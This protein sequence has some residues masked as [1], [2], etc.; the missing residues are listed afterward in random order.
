MEEGDGFGDVPPERAHQEEDH[1][2]KVPPPEEI[3]LGPE[4]TCL[5]ETLMSAIEQE[6]IHPPR[7][8]NWAGW[9]RWR[10]L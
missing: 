1:P 6:V 10:R 9:Q 5:G 8:L 3:N 7:L 2:A 4:V